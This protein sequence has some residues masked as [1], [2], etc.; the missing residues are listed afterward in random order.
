MSLTLM[1]Y[2]H[3][4]Q[5]AEVLT[6]IHLMN[7]C[8]AVVSI[9]QGKCNDTPIPD[10]WRGYSYQL[11]LFGL[12]HSHEAYVERK[13]RWHRWRELA[14]YVA[15]T[16]GGRRD[17]PPWWGDPWVHRSHRSRLLG[18][19]EGHYGDYF[20]A[21]PMHMPLVWPKLTDEDSRGYK[22]ILTKRDLGLIDRKLYR[23]PAGLRWDGKELVS[24]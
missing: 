12:R 15:A 24:A 5:C 9:L 6:D 23:L 2:R 3:Y 18:Y 1:P 19:R 21:T 20:P 14:P 10:M 13:L 16:A 22:L 4:G 17:M 8:D 7:Q 11:V